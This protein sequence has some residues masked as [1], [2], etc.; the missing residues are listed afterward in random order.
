MI[1][2]KENIGNGEENFDPGEGYVLE[3]EPVEVLEEAP[4]VKVSTTKAVVNMTVPTLLV[5]NVKPMPVL[6]LLL[7]A[8][9]SP[10]KRSYTKSSFSTNGEGPNIMEVLL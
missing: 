8:A 1:A 10:K 9:A 5:V 7:T 2:E 3:S 4:R 6:V